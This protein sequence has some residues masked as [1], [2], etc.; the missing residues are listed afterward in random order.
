MPATPPPRGEDP[1]SSASSSGGRPPDVLTADL[2]DRLARAGQAH[3][4]AHAATLPPAARGAFAAELDGVDWA[5]VEL[6]LRSPPPPVP[7]DLRPPEALTLRRRHNEG[8]LGRRLAVAGRKLLAQGRVAAVLLAGGQGTRLGHP[9][10]KGTFVL[11]PSADRS[12]YAI[13]CERVAAAGRAAGRPVPL[14]VLVGRDTEDATRAILADAGRFGLDPSLVRIVRQGEMPA[15]DAD[16]RALLAAPGRLALSPDGHGGLLDALV[17]AGTLAWLLG[18][19][20]EWLTTFQVDNALGRPLDPEFLGW[21]VERRAFAAGKAVRKRTPGEKVG[22]FARGV[23]G[24]VRIVEYSELPATGAEDL[25]LGS[26]A[27]HAWHLPWL[28]ELARA[29]G[30]TLPWHRARKKVAALGADGRVVTPTTENAVKLE[31]FLFD[32]L[33]LA[34]R[35]AVVEVDRRQEF[36]PVKNAT[37]E[38]S[39]ETARAAVAAELVRWHR[40]AARPAP[41]GPLDLRPLEADGPDD[42]RARP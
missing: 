41:E 16:G 35:V 15:F 8:G 11:G 33:P 28:G 7:P 17:R 38:D 29:P 32:L 2:V 22:V 34:P 42:L 23:D 9:G 13:L 6:A 39:P 20:V 1:A 40:E 3:L 26:I 25:T 36:A 12:L 27:V 10:P 19:G 5:R 14:V 31:Q 18:L 37:G 21:A 4:T 30:F 24:R